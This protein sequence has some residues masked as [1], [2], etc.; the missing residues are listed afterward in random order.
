MKQEDKL[1]QKL[2]DSVQKS[3]EYLGTRHTRF[4]SDLAKYKV[5][6]ICKKYANS[7]EYDV[8]LEALVRGG[9]IELIV[10]SIILEEDF[11]SLFS[12]EDLQSAQ[13]RVNYLSKRYRRNPK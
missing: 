4:R 8:H 3:E 2:L 5:V 12:I 1:L 11:R 6:D 9:K 7:I 13:A 10:E